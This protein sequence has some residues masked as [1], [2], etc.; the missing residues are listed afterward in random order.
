M[1]NKDSKEFNEDLKN[2]IMEYY[3][4]MLGA[5]KDPIEALSKSTVMVMLANGIP[6]A[7]Q[8][9]ALEQKKAAEAEKPKE[10]GTARKTDAVARNVAASNAQPPNIAAAGKPNDAKKV[11]D[12]DRMT[13]KEFETLMEDEKRV[14]EALAMYDD[15]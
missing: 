6:S 5:G 13:D 1:L 9:A 11:Y 15:E 2:Q 7:S 10:K 8:A 12:F 14:L 4:P 3:L